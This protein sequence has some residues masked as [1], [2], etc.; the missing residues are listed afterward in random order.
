MLSSAIAACLAQGIE[1][2]ESVRLAKDFVA[3]AIRH[4]PKLRPD[5]VTLELTELTEQ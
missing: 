4:A 2:G 1:L 3:S 5:P